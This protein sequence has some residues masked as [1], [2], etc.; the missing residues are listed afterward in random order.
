MRLRGRSSNSSSSTASS[1]A[2]SGVLKM[3]VMPAQAPATSKVLR[4]AAV[5]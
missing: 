1:K 2:A 4:S 3:A 5:R